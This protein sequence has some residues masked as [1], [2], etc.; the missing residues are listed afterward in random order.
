MLK[1]SGS[2]F[3]VR[4]PVTNQENKFYLV[5]ASGATAKEWYWNDADYPGDPL[6]KGLIW[7]DYLGKFVAMTDSVTHV[8]SDGIAWISGSESIDDTT[9]PYLAPTFGIAVANDLGKLVIGRDNGYLSK[10]IAYSTDGLNWSASTASAANM[11]VR[12]ITYSPTL[13]RF[14]AVGLSGTYEPNVAYSDD[15]INFTVVSSSTYITSA[16]NMQQFFDVTWDESGSQFVATGDYDSI[17]GYYSGSIHTSTDGI[18]WNIRTIIHPSANFYSSFFYKIIAVSGSYII[19]SD[20]PNT[21][22]PSKAIVYSSGSITNWTYATNLPIVAGDLYDVTYSPYLNKFVAVGQP[23][24]YSAKPTMLYSSNIL[25]W[26]S[27]SLSVYAPSDTI[28]SI[29]WSPTEKKF[30]ALGTFET[31]YSYDGE[32]FFTKNESYTGSVGFTSIPAGTLYDTPLTPWTSSLTTTFNKSDTTYT[33][34]LFTLMRGPDGVYPSA[35]VYYIPTSSYGIVIDSASLT[36]F[37]TVST[38]TYMED[39]EIDG[40]RYLREITQE[41]GN[42]YAKS[43]E[44]E[45]QTATSTLYNY[46]TSS[47]TASL[48]AAGR[49]YVMLRYGVSGAVVGDEVAM[50]LNLA[51]GV[52]E[53]YEDASNKDDVGSDLIG[54]TTMRFIDIPTLTPKLNNYWQLKFKAGFGDVLT[55]SGSVTIKPNIAPSVIPLTLTRSTLGRLAAHTT[56]AISDVTTVFTSS[57]WGP[58]SNVTVSTAGSTLDF[59]SLSA[60]IFRTMPY[61]PISPISESFVQMVGE[62]ISTGG[63]LGAVARADSGSTEYDG[64]WMSLS[65]GFSGPLGLRE[66]ENGSNIATDTITTSLLS[67]D[68]QYRVSLY[69]D[70]SNGSF[71]HYFGGFGLTATS[72]YALTLTRGGTGVYS[73][74]VGLI[75]SRGTGGTTRYWEFY[76]MTSRYV[77]VSGL[78]TSA[79]VQVRN[80]GG[81]VLSSATASAGT[82]QV[83]MLKVEFPT[84][85]E[86]R[87]LDSS[88]NVLITATPSQR[89]WGGDIWV[90]G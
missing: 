62:V 84:A 41:P 8:S 2:E 25:D 7:A 57:N 89:V 63:S 28:V 90:Y 42:E 73:G 31:F 39:V 52:V 38:D 33:Y 50:I 15:G 27:A 54:N 17:S 69:T 21:V 22:S 80:S 76:V 34:A 9:N 11:F 44:L 74:S 55:R 48:K 26:Y 59:T 81:T 3:V 35:D 14:V 45:Y 60:N 29:A 23:E 67:A 47:F 16:S 64:V 58:K 20:N 32:K 10:P 37:P 78:P 5:S 12:G 56:T 66:I 53:Q 4:D 40:I 61:N 70:A 72:S 65:P 13:Q 6:Y 36:Q 77:T 86:I 46:Y 75:H 49:N 1:E 43:N 85:T 82:A 30:V 83:D 79:S 18:N 87:V 68:D 88:S 24:A 71:G 51:D 19:A